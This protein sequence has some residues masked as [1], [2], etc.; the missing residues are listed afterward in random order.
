MKPSAGNVPKAPECNVNDPMSCDKRKHEV[1][2]FSDGQYRC[3]CPNGFSRLPDGRCLVIN[4]CRDPR[5]NECSKDADCIDQ[6]SGN[7]LVEQYAQR[8]FCIP[9]FSGRRLHL[10]M[11]N[12]LCR[13]FSKWTNWK[14]LPTSYQ[15][16]QQSPSI[17]CKL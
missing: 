2:L 12:W 7:I 17:R 4:E 6:V 14:N 13:C 3:T 5:L 8:H 10:S 15:R 11:S 9:N 16:V 1:C